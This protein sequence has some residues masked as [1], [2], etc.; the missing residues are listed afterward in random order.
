MIKREG[1]IYSRVSSHKQVREGNGLE[2]QHASCMAHAQSMNIKVINSF[3]DAGLSGGNVNRPGLIEL[4]TFIG[5]LQHDVYVFIDDISRL[6]RD[7]H[8]YY[9]L[10]RLIVSEGGILESVK[11]DLAETPEGKFFELIQIG[12]ADLNRQLNRLRVMSRMRQRMLKGYWVFQA[13]VGY[14]KLKRPELI[15]D[16]RNSFLI[17]KIFED[18]SNGKY[19]TYK[20]IKDSLE[21]KSLTNKKNRPFKLKD[22]FIKRLLSNSLY[23]GKIQ[24]EK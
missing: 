6:S 19:S 12:V 18:F 11:N 9:A 14:K 17:K 3:E 15:E 13:P 7:T 22:D 8:E 10:R 2:S 1:V 21:A 5:S 20:Q 4:I 23:V 16:K 24:Y